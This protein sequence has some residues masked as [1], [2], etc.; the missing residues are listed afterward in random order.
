ML[1]INSP[2]AFIL[3][4]AS[5]PEGFIEDD[6]VWSLAFDHS[7]AHPFHLTTTYGLKARAVQVFPEIF[8][9][10]APL[11]NLNAAYTPPKITRYA[12]G[13]LQV[14]LRYDAGLTLTFT[15]ST[16]EPNV[17]AGRILVENQGES[18]LHFKQALAFHLLP[19]GK[20]VKTRSGKAG[21]H[22]ILTA[23]SG[24][25]SAVMAMSGG[26]ISTNTP[27]P[28]LMRPLQLGP[29][30]S[31]STDWALAA[32]Q[33]HE[34][35][36]RTAQ[37]YSRQI[38]SQDQ[39]QRLMDHSRQTIHIQTGNK[40]WDAAFFLAQV[41]SQTH[42]IACGSA[43][44][45]PAVVRNRLP[46]AP[47]LNTRNLSK[48]DDL[49]TLELVHL[50]QVL[51]PQQTS[52]MAQL[53][54][55]FLHRITEDGQL[56]TRRSASPFIKPYDEPPV[57]A[58][59][60]LEIFEVTQDPAFL[61]QAFPHLTQ[62]ANGWLFSDAESRQEKPLSWQDPEQCQLASG[63]Y[64]FDIWE[65]SGGGLDIRAMESP[66][67]LAMLLREARSLGKIAEELAATAS[68]RRWERIEAR[69]RNTL[70]GLWHEGQ[71]T[72]R[73]RDSHSQAVQSREELLRT[74]AQTTLNLDRRFKDPQRLVCH[75]AAHDERTRVCRLTL[76]GLDS[77]G[78]EQVEVYRPGEIRWIAGR[79]HITTRNLFSVLRTVSQTGLMP[80]DEIHLETAGLSQ[81][82]ITCFAPIWAGSLTASR[83]QALLDHHLDPSHPGL[84]RGLPEIFPGGDEPPKDVMDAVNVLWNTL[85]IQGLARSSRTESAA[86]LF[87]NLMATISSGLKDFGGFFPAYQTQDGRPLGPI[88]AVAGLAPLRLCLEIAG[89]RLLSPWKVAIWGANP[90]PWPIEAQWQGL[91][92]SKDSQHTQITFPDG[93]TF[94]HE[95]CEPVTITPQHRGQP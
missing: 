16:S 60:C 38:G 2:K 24:G 54:M 39:Q 4:A 7:D 52:M 27:Y 57:L 75:L 33:T 31:H 79:A 94:T 25:L 62:L 87:T 43:G 83:L 89:V 64:P 53:V 77:T 73:Y 56:L 59:L 50:A 76:A 69:L 47:P 21:T 26:P 74:F 93:T 29:G 40:D 3:A 11:S 84:L 72:Y 36:L 86:A 68:A 65:R 37:H 92:L 91:T 78:A 18:I 81:A 9:A 44:E 20:G 15:A 71:Q 70:D 14:V 85:V 5:W 28:A 51:L 46:D 34:S 88:N 61:Q 13:V 17:L 32:R 80:E 45:A 55:K 10:T 19:L 30:E 12:P 22:H 41:I 35:A 82:D 48:R 58:S 66:A 8:F 42:F 63:F 6:Q 67:L 49:T 1:D 95:G 23:E 90:F